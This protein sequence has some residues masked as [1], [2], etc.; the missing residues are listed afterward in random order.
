M[1]IMG[2]DPGTGSK[3]AL[4]MA[5]VDVRRR[6]LLRWEEYVAKGAAW[7]RIRSV[8]GQ[9]KGAI[10]ACPDVEAIASEYFVMRGKGGETLSRL[11]GGLIV[12]IPDG[13]KFIEVQ[14]STIKKVLTG[15]GDAS[16]EEVAAAVLNYFKDDW[17]SYSTVKTL[18]AEESWDAIDAMAIAIA[19]SQAS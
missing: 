11:V 5:V 19:G 18:I 16:K 7:E 9:L 10:I 8:I 4:G 17:E 15:R 1:I 12:S 3:S 13:T 2:V 6:V 14:N